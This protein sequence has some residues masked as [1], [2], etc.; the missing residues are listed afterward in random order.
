[1]RVGRLD[2]GAMLMTREQKSSVVAHKVD[3][4]TDDIG[5][6]F[7]GLVFFLLLFLFM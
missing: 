5:R 2:I 7:V 1:M 4:S 6:G 3:M